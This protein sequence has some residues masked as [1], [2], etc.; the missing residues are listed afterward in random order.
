[1]HVRWLTI[2]LDFPADGFSAGAEFWREVTGSGRSAFRGAGQVF[3]T[4]LPRSGDPWLRVQ[5]VASGPGGC[6]LDLHVDPSA[7]ALDDAAAEAVAAG[8]VVRHREDGLIVAESP[9]GLAFCLVEWEGEATAPE[10]AAAVDG[11]ADQL[12]LDAPP[13]QFAAEARFWARLL[14]LTARHTVGGHPEFAYLGQAAGGVRLVVQ[15]KQE[16][17]P[18]ARVTGH[19]DVVCADLNGATRRHEAAG[20]RVRARLDWWTVLTDPAGR[21]Y[22]LV[23][24][25]RSARARLDVATGS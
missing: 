4:L 20:S 6:H 10:P 13:G 14:G 21:E 15:R 8:A 18:G 22:C 17:A 1:M 24:A 19:L 23:D 12:C 9:G 5:R 7:Q 25:A 3:A 16:A 2:F 11:L